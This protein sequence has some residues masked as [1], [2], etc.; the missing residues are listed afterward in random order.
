MLDHLPGSVHLAND[1]DELYEQLGSL[2]M[3]C[4]FEAVGSR[5][6]FHLALSGGSTPERFYM[7]LVT[8]PRFRDLPWKQTHIWVVD[9][10]RV[11]ETDDQSNWKMM[12]ES[13]VAH[14][15]VRR[16]QTHPMPVLDADPAATYE[17][18]LHHALGDEGR[19]DFVL[20][21]MGDDGHTASIFPQSDAVHVRDRWVTVNDGPHVTPPPRVTMTYPLLNAA[22]RIVVLVTG[23]KKSARLRD[24]DEQMATSG[25]DPDRLP[26][27]GIDPPDGKLTWYLD[28]AAAG[29]TTS[30]PS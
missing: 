26:I 24:V 6:E 28:N 3:V 11:P 9:E 8:D 21:G 15:P 18:A 20:L 23:E 19:L 16:R 30:Q 1:V 22:R 17:A 27:T 10:R 29:L 14:V 13:L 12:T 25:P 5:G 4:A 2:L 7:C